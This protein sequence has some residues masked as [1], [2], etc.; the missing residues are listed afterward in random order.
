TDDTQMMIGVTQA[1]IQD[2]QIES[3]TLQHYFVKNY[4]ASRGYGRGA[5][6]VLQAMSEGADHRHWVDSQFPGGSFGNGAA[7]R[8]APIGLVF[9]HDST[10]LFEQADL[11]SK[12][13]HT[14]PL[15]TEGARLIAMAVAYCVSSRNFDRNE[16]FD[17]LLECATSEEYRHKIRMAAAATKLSDLESI[18]N[19]IAAHESVVTAIGC[20]ALT[21]NDYA[22]T[23]AHAILL[24]GDTDTIAAM[25]GAISGAYQGESAIPSVWLSAL[26]DDYQGHT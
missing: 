21:P 16:F 19:G 25:A 4:V 18:G 24:G 1:L 20:F 12:L 2:G 3:A 17:R 9:R 11:Q 7:M 8:V 26:E 23:I 10:K 22:R 6:M 5:R 13:T 14:H 15:G